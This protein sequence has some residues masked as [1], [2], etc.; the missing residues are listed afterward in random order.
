MPPAIASAVFAIGILGL[1]MLDR[2]RDAKTSK[3]LWIPVLWLLIN[4]SRPVSMW[5]QMSTPIDTPDQYLDGSPFDRT[6]YLVLLV[7]GL[8]VLLRRGRQVATLL[9]ANA[10]IILFFLYCFASIF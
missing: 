2:D 4:G 6:V 7:A 8:I 10:P 9:R 1:F 5:L 3:A